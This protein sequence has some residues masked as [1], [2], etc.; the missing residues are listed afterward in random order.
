MPIAP[1]VRTQRSL[2]RPWVLLLLRVRPRHAY[3][4][5][6]DLRELGA[7]HP[8]PGT[9]YRLLNDL[10][11]AKLVRSMWG[12]SPAGPDRRV[13]RVTASGTRQ[14]RRDAQAL[15]ELS[16]DLRRFAAEWQPLD[17]HLAKR[18]R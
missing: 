6:D 5:M 17:A 2:L 10:N 14:L 1:P 16:A 15:E 7:P 8:D 4:L 3:E 13:Y 18:R 9:L 11:E 12:P